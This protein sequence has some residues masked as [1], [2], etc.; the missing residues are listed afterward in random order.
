MVF[1]QVICFC[2]ILEIFVLH[3][4]KCK[5]QQSCQTPDFVKSLVQFR[6]CSAKSIS[7]YD[8]T[9]STTMV[10]P[11]TQHNIFM[12]LITE[13]FTS[14]KTAFTVGAEWVFF[15]FLAQQHNGG[16]FQSLFQIPDSFQEY[17]VISCQFLIGL[18][19]YGKNHNQVYFYRVN[20]YMVVNGCQLWL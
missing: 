15:C 14:N 10:R 8:C 11:Q 9:S 6:L 18:R 5:C 7:S 16:Y 20:V 2:D 12:S 4:T 1:I 3:Y 19:D 17:D 13:H